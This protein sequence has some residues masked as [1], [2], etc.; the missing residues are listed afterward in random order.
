[1]LIKYIQSIYIIKVCFKQVQ[2]QNTKKDFYYYF[3][4]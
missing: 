3:K 4:Y 1:M 2:I